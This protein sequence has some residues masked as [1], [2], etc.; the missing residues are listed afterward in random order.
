PGRIRA[1]LPVSL[2]HYRDR[3]SSEFQTLV[4]Q[5]YK[6]MILLAATAVMSLVVVLTNRLVWRPLYRLANEKYQLL[7]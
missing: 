6:I 2:S 7:A 3:K 1:N 5:V 4:D